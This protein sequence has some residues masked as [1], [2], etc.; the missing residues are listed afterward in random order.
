MD[1]HESDIGRLLVGVVNLSHLSRHQ[2]YRVLK[3]KPNSDP[4]SYPRTRS[5]RSC[6]YFEV[7]RAKF[8]SIIADESTDTANKELSLVLR[9][10]VDNGIKEVFADFRS[11]EDFRLFI[12]NGYSEMA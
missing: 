4:S 7:K 3:T 9:Y 8:Y 2:I 5:C 6:R 10:V 11:R 1:Q 12:G